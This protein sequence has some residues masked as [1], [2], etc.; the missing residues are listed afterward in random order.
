MPVLLDLPLGRDAERHLFESDGAAAPD[1]LNAEAMHVLQAHERRG[2]IDAGR[3][4]EALK[5]LLDLPVIRYPTLQLAERA[6][7]LRSN[8]TAYDAM[9]VALAEAL[10]ATLVTA[11]GG[12]A[13]AARAHT[14]VPVVLLK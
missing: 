11:D 2:V 10:D 1:L 13:R 4:R 8:L 7:E 14:A 6:W 9:Y 3:S 12:L 5:D